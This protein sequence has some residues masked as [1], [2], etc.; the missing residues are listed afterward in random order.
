MSIFSDTET[1]ETWLRQQCDVVEE[2][3]D[4]KHRRM[5]K[6]PF[7]FLRATFFRWARRIGKICPELATAPGVL[8]VGDAHL[9]NFGTWRDLEGRLVWGVND[10]DEVA[11]MPYAFDLVRLA[12]SVRLAPH[13]HIAGGEAAERIARGY[14]RGLRAPRPILLDEQETWMRR[15]VVCSDEERKE[16][17]AE[18]EDYPLAVPPPAVAA[19]LMKSLPD[20]VQLV[21]FASRR[22]GG[23]GLGRPRFVAVAAWRGGLVVREAKALLPSAWEWARGAAAPTSR[24]LDAA[25]G[26]YRSPDPY[27][28]V[29]D[30]FIL[31]RIAADS[32]K[33]E[34]GEHAGEELHARLL[35]AM[36][37][38]LGSIH[39][40]DPAVPA[41][42]AH[43]AASP[44]DWLEKAAEA[45]AEWV[46]SDFDRW[47]EREG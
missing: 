4:H 35:E 16:F 25:K 21:R 45:A 14:G 19:A 47:C 15:W 20:G 37:F 23:G 22:K 28:D 36:G 8:A 18:V 13:R 38:D 39:A 6:D 11:V 24:A 42:R 29:A 41:V 17:W 32:R 9:E 7:V 30:N 46:K 3:L 31:R 27:L 40:A 10:F 1:Y 33:V 44:G 12:T 5:A 43:L 2:D 26:A 34:L